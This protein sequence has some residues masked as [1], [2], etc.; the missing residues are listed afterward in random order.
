MIANLLNTLVGLW[1]TYAAF[2]RT[3]SAWVAIE[4][5]SSP[6]LHNRGVPRCSDDH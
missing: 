1:L 6:P 5:P 4:L 2:F 3:P